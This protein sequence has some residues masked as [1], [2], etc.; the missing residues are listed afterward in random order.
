MQGRQ[1]EHPSSV[2]RDHD[3]E[4]S[5]GR[6]LVFVVLVY[7]YRVAQSDS[8]SQ[9]ATGESIA[10]LWAPHR[11]NHLYSYYNVVECRKAL[12]FDQGRHPD[13]HERRGADRD[14]DDNF[15]FLLRDVQN[16]AVVC[17]RVRHGAVAVRTPDACYDRRGMLSPKPFLADERSWF[18][19]VF[20][21]YLQ[22]DQ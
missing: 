14:F 15:V 18:A 3:R 20:D 12:R 2:R 6:P 7:R 16:T 22:F 21:Q 8:L 17:V 11:P 4:V 13:T 19:V 9:E 10:S 5:R 1:A